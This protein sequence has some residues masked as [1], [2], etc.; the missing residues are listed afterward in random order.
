VPGASPFLRNLLSW[1]N[2]N[3][4]QP[5]VSGIYPGQLRARRRFTILALFQNQFHS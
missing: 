3:Y 1:L 2:R 5:D 4:P